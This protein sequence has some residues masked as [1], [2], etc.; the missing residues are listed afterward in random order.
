[1][2]TYIITTISFIILFF[3]SACGNNEG[4]SV[5]KQ[6]RHLIFE[7][8][9]NST[10]VDMHEHQPIFISKKEGHHEYVI[11]YHLKRGQEV[12]FCHINHKNPVKIEFF[13]E[14]NQMILYHEE[15]VG[16]KSI[17]L[18]EGNYT[19]HVT[20][21]NHENIFIHNHYIKNSK[22][23]NS[24]VTCSKSECVIHNIETNG[25]QNC[26]FS[27]AFLSP[28]INESTG[29]GEAGLV[30]FSHHNFKNTTWTKMAFVNINFDGSDFTG[31]TF[32]DSCSGGDCT[33]STNGVYGAG[34]S[35]KNAKFDS[36]R[37]NAGAIAGDFSKAT[38]KDGNIS[39]SF[40]F[41]YYNDMTSNA[42]EIMPQIYQDRFGEDKDMGD[43]SQFKIDGV[44]G[45]N[46][47]LNDIDFS[48]TSIGDGESNLKLFSML[49][50]K[51]V[52]FPSQM[53]LVGIDLHKN[54]LSGADFS[55]VT[56]SMSE[57]NLKDANLK[58]ANL[59]NIEF[60]NADFTCVDFENSDVSGIDF[61]TISFSQDSGC[62]YNF[63]GV[64]LGA[65]KNFTN[66]TL[67][68]L[69]DIGSNFNGADFSN[70]T[71]EDTDFSDF[72]C[73]DCQFKHAIFDNV[74]FKN[75]DFSNANL[76]NAT[77]KN[78]NINALQLASASMRNV[79]FSAVSDWNNSMLYR[80]NLEKIKFENMD[81]KNLDFH[82]LYLR[83]ADFS[84]HDL[85]N[86]NFK[87]AD[88]RGANFTNARL[89]AYT[90]LSGANLTGSNFTRATLK[91]T[92][93]DVE[94]LE[95]INFT[96]V[97]FTDY[98]FFVGSMD[99]VAFDE[100]IL[101]NTNFSQVSNYRNMSF[102]NAS[103]QGANLSYRVMHKTDFSGADLKDANCKE[104]DFTGS[105][106][107]S[108]TI[109]TADFTNGT[110]FSGADLSGLDFSNHKT[111]TYMNFSHIK[112]VGTGFSNIDMSYTN[113]RYADCH[114]HKTGANFENTTL[115]SADLRNAD[116]RYTRFYNVN[117]NS[118]TDFT[119]SDLRYSNFMRS[120]IE[121][122]IFTRNTNFS[123][124]DL[125][126]VDFSSHKTL[127]YMN[128]SHIKCKG[129][130][131]KNIDLSHT[132]FEYADCSGGDTSFS[133]ATMKDIDISNADM[134][135]VYFNSTNITG[136]KSRLKCSGAHVND[137]YTKDD[138][139]HAP[140]KWFGDQ[141]DSWTDTGA[142]L[143]YNCEL[144][145]TTF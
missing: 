54:D 132:T 131:F 61:N 66:A 96:G 140:T 42:K 124:A 28:D 92:R 16:C 64:N 47:I 53:N 119:D 114:A 86:S 121:H 142:R 67:K 90:K 94:Y 35:F 65:S 105:D 93:L 141:C 109:A 34:N 62:S 108:S 1:M 87:Y 100:A 120:D 73:K 75:T 112:C 70:L 137:E 80:T 25:C 79:K 10:T 5:I 95:S 101:K 37:F 4:S 26:N 43:L 81:L 69:Q 122:A 49:S 29:L 116:M 97:D 118:D 143:I 7:R 9:L 102:K 45:E 33:G 21:N 129:T 77:I 50:M 107:R 117:F 144:D 85:N 82:K 74:T 104:A 15:T 52:I 8:D 18:E 128:F 24:D 51:N 136:S 135:G 63:S 20:A 111:L 103:M 83:G 71:F 126:G 138:V 57:A 123:Y 48:S 32:G 38:F 23:R 72:T 145:C 125:S 44:N 17:D 78:S 11:L 31:A 106:F 76:E 22:T 113:M 55:H 13:D 134:S 30:D 89:D 2:K 133:G 3:I 14:N 6:P 139:Y 127:T 41:F 59:S 110:N 88:L 19:L 39:N 68:K 91:Y 60:V 36:A 58:G 84:N 12:H 40:K 115:N 98:I 56:S 46:A 99:S 130:N 27:Y